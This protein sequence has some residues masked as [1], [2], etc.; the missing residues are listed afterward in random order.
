MKILKTFKK[1]NTL[2]NKGDVFLGTQT[3][4]LAINEKLGLAIEIVQKP[5]R[6][7]KKK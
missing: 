1:D 4:A 2:F 3:E 6:K 7:Y 5:K